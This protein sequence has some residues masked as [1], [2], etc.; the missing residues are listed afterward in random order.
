MVILFIFILG[1][2]LGSFVGALSYR[3]PRGVSIA[4]GRSFCPLCKVQIAWHDNIPLISYLI[5]GGRC[6]HCGKKIS[7]RYPLIEFST[8]ILFVGVFILR[9]II[10]I[11]LG[12][13]AWWLLLALI[14]LFVCLF[15]IDWEHQILPDELIFLG[16]ALAIG[17]FVLNDQQII[18]ANLLAGFAGSIFLLIIYF[19][20]LGRGMG[21]GDVKLAILL[22]LILG[23]SLTVLLFFVSFIIG[24]SLGAILLAT[25]NAKLKDKIAFGPFLIVGFFVT[26]FLG[27]QMQ[28]FLL[29]LTATML[30]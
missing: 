6:R 16:I 11:N 3:A 22:G 4:K 24:G 27:S 29:P 5:L 25:K 18:F 2:L 9:N 30:K 12:W 14:P 7:P 1:L 8:A 19:A 10:F 28:Y 13:Q 23:P 20:T 26:L 17:F 15:V 21:L